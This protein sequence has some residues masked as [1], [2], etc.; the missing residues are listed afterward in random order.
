MLGSA[1]V[2]GNESPDVEGAVYCRIRVACVLESDEGYLGV[3]ESNE[4][5]RDVPLPLCVCV[6]SGLRCAGWPM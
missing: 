2:P 4:G 1:R 6:E 5:Y 3:L